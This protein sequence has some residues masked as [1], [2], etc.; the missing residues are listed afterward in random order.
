MKR[1]SQRLLLSF[2]VAFGLGLM[3]AINVPSLGMKYLLQ[4]TILPVLGLFALLSIAEINR[5]TQTTKWK[6]TYVIVFLAALVGGF[7]VLWQLGYMQGVA[8]KFISVL[9]PFSRDATPL[10]ESVAEHRISA[11]GSIYY[12]LGIGILFFSIGIFFA[13]GN[14]S[15]RNIF[16]LIYG[17]TS[18]YFACSMVRLLVLMAPAFALLV[19]IGLTGLLK[20]FSTLLKEPPKIG[21]KKKLGLE[22]VGKEFSGVAIFLIFII[23]MSTMAFPSPKV[24][25]QAYAPVTI[26]AGSL[27]I[28]P[29]E[30]VAEW[31]N[32]LA[33]TGNNL[34]SKTVVCSWW[35][36]GY[37][38]TILGNVTSLADNA[39]INSTQIQNIGFIF[40][41]N[42]TQAIKMMKRYNSSYIL[43]F[44]TTGYDGN[45]VDWAGGDNGKWT[46]MARISGSG[47]DRL[48]NKEKVIDQ[49]SMWTNETSFGFFN[50]S[51]NSGQGAWQWTAPT[52]M[53]TMIYKL[54]A[55]GKHRWCET[56][57]VTDPEETQ[58]TKNNLTAA[59][60]EPVY[61]KEAYFAGVSLSANDAKSKYGGIVPLV[62]LYQIDWAKYNADHPNG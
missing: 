4:F 38:L 11:W 40:M 57:S 2:S 8:G 50:S 48:V 7:A 55:W 24:F 46:W 16:L 62:C 56:N 25:R 31:F 41:S 52:G 34:N 61:F 45:W 22:Y 39:T 30:P 43:V 18:L 3:I 1:Y 47:R 6:L 36:Y 49:K 27:S 15:N 59:N 53:T 26:T 21:L 29:N 37:W 51:L 32:M 44:V 35:D 20:P 5:V 28:A 33:W 12:D 60:I 9:N 17:L 58:W 42:E 23:L 19:A 54:M 10:I 13:L 14:L